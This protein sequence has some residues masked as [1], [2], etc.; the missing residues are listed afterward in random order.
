MTI[1]KQN[2][3]MPK[4]KKSPS[5]KKA[6]KAPR[7]IEDL[8]PWQW[9]IR[10]AAKDLK[11]QQNDGKK[12]KIGIADIVQLAKALYCKMSGREASTL[13]VAGRTSPE[14]LVVKKK[15][16]YSPKPGARYV[17]KEEWLDQEVDPDAKKVKKA[18]KSVAVKRAK[19]AKNCC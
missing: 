14:Q 19:R 4:A 10:K 5:K 6:P 15:H 8:T 11:A 1:Q 16:C 3:T 2:P 9:C 12:G 17:P 13:N 7:A 18:K